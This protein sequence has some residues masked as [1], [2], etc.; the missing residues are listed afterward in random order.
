MKISLIGAGQIGGIL[1]FLA[2]LDRVF[3]EII[4]YDVVE[5]LPQGKALDISHSLSVIGSSSRLKGTNEISEITGSD[6][7]IITAGVARKPNMSRDDLLF[8]NAK[9]I[10]DIGTQIKHLAPDSIC[11]VVTN[12]LDAMSWLM[13]KKT[14][15]QSNR[16][17]GMA[18]MLDSGRYSFYLSEKLGV[19]PVSIEALVLGGHGDDMVPVRHCTNVNGLPISNFLSDDD[20]EKVEDR[21]KNAGGEVLKLLQTGSAFFSPAVC[22]YRMA[23]AIVFDENLATVASCYLNG[24]YGLTDIFFGVPCILGKGGVKKVLEINL[25]EREINQLNL[26]AERIKKLIEQL[27]NV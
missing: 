27:R 2:A 1:A 13:M 4:L 8:T 7:I 17:V 21:V 10:S 23:K 14:G 20:L 25:S 18:G 15:F 19:S 22:A 26:S 12:P 24:E 11:I 6:V 5:G 3:S 16:V 9:I